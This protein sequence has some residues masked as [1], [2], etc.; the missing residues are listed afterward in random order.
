MN[1]N[2]TKA[3]NAI[4]V[5]DNGN[6]ML[7]IMQYEGKFYWAM[8]DKSKELLCLYSDCTEIYESLYNELL[9][10]AFEDI[11]LKVQDLRRE[12]TELKIKADKWDAHCA[13][14]NTGS[15]KKH[16]SKK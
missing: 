13:K 6:S 11:A 5:I 1:S 10:K 3:L 8:H 15:Y 9:R 16:R 12:R 2:E 14:K 7:S 4:P